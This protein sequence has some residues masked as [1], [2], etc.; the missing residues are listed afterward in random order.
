M[1]RQLQINE[2]IVNYRFGLNILKHIFICSN[3]FRGRDAWAPVS[4]LSV[5]LCANE[6]NTFYENSIGTACDT[7]RSSY[8]RVSV[9]FVLS[10]ID[11]E[12]R[13]RL[14]PRC[15]VLC[16]KGFVLSDR[17]NNGVK[18]CAPMFP[19]RQRVVADNVLAKIRMEITRE[20][21]RQIN[22][23]SKALRTNGRIQLGFKTFKRSSNTEIILW[24]NHPCTCVDG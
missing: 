2:I 21:C 20:I 19:Y 15:R 8:V 12:I 17:K 16:R 9:C 1:T 18:M 13:K 10:L 4:L 7:K 24:D 3:I 14:S 11:W 23:N 6:L 22:L 5:L